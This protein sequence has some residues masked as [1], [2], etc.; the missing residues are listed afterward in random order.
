MT[1]LLAVDPLISSPVDV[2]VAPA[3][4]QRRLT[5]LVRLILAIPQFVVL[6]FVS[7]G[8]F[9]VVV[10]GW[11]AALVSGRLPASFGRFLSGYVRWQVRVLAYT[12]F[13]T[14]RYPPFSL[15]ADP[16]YP[17]DLAVT[18]GRLNRAAVLFRIVLFVPVYFADAAFLYGMYGVGVVTWAITLVRGRV[19]DSLFGASA[20][21]IRY[22]ARVTGYLYLVTSVYPNGLFGDRM[23]YGGRLDGS[24]IEAPFSGTPPAEPPPPVTP[25]GPSG[26][27]G[28]Q[29]AAPAPAHAPGAV[30]RIQVGLPTI[31]SPVMG[32]APDSA[33]PGTPGPGTWTRWPLVLTRAARRMV[34]V[35]LVVGAVTY[36]GYLFVLRPALH[37]PSIQAV[38]AANQ[39][40]SAYR[41]V[42]AA[43]QTFDTSLS[44]CPTDDDSAELQC[45]QQANFTWSAALGAYSNRLSLIDFPASSQTEAEAAEAAADR[46]SNAVFDLATSQDLPSFEETARSKVFRSDVDGVEPAYVGL[47]DSLTR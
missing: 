39:T 34:V 25:Y 31:D 46:A 18:S 21:A 36:G 24:R 27:G 7:I 26:A 9:V 5:V 22:H 32:P 11:F 41:I 33:D 6:G 1:V 15:D 47:F 29:V 19:P 2:R 16:G 8:A 12:F 14:D 23:D 17:V 40:E 30:G 37:L 44:T 4:A 28:D 3:E 20:A 45:L 35:F 10:L 42:V 43:G 38:I 13:L